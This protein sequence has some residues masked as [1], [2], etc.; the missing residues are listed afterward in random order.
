MMHN[1]TAEGRPLDRLGV[2]RQAHDGTVRFSQIVSPI[3]SRFSRFFLA[4]C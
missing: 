1:R 3:V 2:V 4:F